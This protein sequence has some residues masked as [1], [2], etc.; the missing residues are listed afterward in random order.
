MKKKIHVLYT[1]FAAWFIVG[2]AIGLI[3]RGI[4][5]RDTQNYWELQPELFA[6]DEI[7][8]VLRD[9]EHKT[10]YVCYY[11]TSYVNVYNES[12][13]FLWAVSTPYLR[14]PYYELQKDRLII[15]DIDAYIYNSADGSFIECVNAEDLTLEYNWLNETTDEILEGEF[16]FG[17][18]QV[19]RGNSD[20]TLE[21]IVA[22]PWWYWCFNFSM[23]WIFAFIGAIGIGITVF[24]QKRK[25]YK[26]VKKNVKL[27]NRKQK[28][29][30]HYFRITSAVQIVYAV[31]NIIFGFFGG[32]LCIGLIPIGIHFIFSS[33]I[34]HNMLDHMSVAEDEMTVLNYWRLV[35]L[36]SFLA[37]FFSVAAVAI[38]FGQQMYF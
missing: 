11:D 8:T 17:T 7:S 2:V 27:K 1:I 29:M 33:I 26:L 16:Y 13:E 25:E 38:F 36:F 14:N 6:P 24:L 3:G 37:A 19:Y 22:R 18:Y 32:I 15:Y 31:L 9:K 35:E 12:G 4:C 21:T 10:L 23:C 30:Y 20:E 5:I 34:L 28:V